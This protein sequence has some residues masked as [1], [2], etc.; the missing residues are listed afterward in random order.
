MDHKMNTTEFRDGFRIGAGL[1]SQSAADDHWAWYS[2]QLSDR[3]RE[4]IEAGGYDAGFEQGTE[5]R[6][7]YC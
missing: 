4:E 5:F 6:E 3:E 1:T 2:R 7:L